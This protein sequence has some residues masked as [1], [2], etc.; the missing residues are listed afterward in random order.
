M[1]LEEDAESK[2]TLW[3]EDEPSISGIK[4]QEEYVDP[5]AVLLERVKPKHDCGT[6]FVRRLQSRRQK[7]ELLAR[8]LSIPEE[9]ETAP[10]NMKLQLAKCKA[11]NDWKRYPS[12]Q[13]HRAIIPERSFSD[14]QLLLLS[15]SN[16]F[17]S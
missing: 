9:N 5:F 15:C 1:N 16:S 12:L 11:L 4:V 2:T 7:L 14:I 6:P 10:Q 8:S 17:P 13:V 3:E